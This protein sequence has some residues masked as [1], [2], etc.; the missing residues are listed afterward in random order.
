MRPSIDD[1]ARIMAKDSSFEETKHP[2]DHG[3]FSSSGGGGGPSGGAAPDK[4]EATG[5]GG[6]YKTPAGKPYG[7]MSAGEALAEY[8]RLAKEN[9]LSSAGIDPKN[10]I[11]SD[12]KVLR[13]TLAAA[14]PSKAQ[15]ILDGVGRFLLL[16]WLSD[17]F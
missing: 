6:E 3:K 1:L 15:A 7:Q 2:R 16:G 11:K 8:A 13:A 14:S 5:G 10:P 9:D 17:V 12:K 4:P